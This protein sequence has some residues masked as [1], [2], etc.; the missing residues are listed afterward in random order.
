MTPPVKFKEKRLC[1]DCGRERGGC[2]AIILTAEKE[3]L[4]VCPTCW[5]AFEYEEFMR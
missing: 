2:Y 5:R 3:T 4:C 1:N